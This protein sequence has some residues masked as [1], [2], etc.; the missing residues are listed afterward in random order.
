M[1][2]EVAL[3]AMRHSEVDLWVVRH[4]EALGLCVVSEVQ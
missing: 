1:G 2:C 3:W 4:S